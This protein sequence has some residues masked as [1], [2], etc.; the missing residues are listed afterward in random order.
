MSPTGMLF[1]VI[2]SAALVVLFL[3]SVR[4]QFYTAQQLR[5]WP[6]PPL[7]LLRHFR[8]FSP[9]PIRTDV[10][11]IA[12]DFRQNGAPMPCRE[13]PL[14][15][16][17]HWTHALWNP[18]KRRSLPLMTIMVELTAIGTALG[19]DR[20]AAVL[21]TPYLILLGVVSSH[22]PTDAWGRQF[23]LVESFGFE[24]ELDT[25]VLFCSAVHRLDRAEIG[26]DRHLPR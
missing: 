9:K 21:S 17:R 15:E 13:I 6:A 26:S 8:L 4:Y 19:E 7:K 18:G 14:I 2:P 22:A 10:H 3:L 16:V 11:L 12:R 24:R 5:E 20:A 23:L 25:Q 1:G